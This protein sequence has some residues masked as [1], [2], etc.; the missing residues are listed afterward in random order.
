[1]QEAGLEQRCVGREV[2]A[3]SID[4]IPQNGV[5]Q[6]SEHVQRSFFCCPM[7]PLSDKTAQNM[8]IF[9]YRFVQVEHVVE[10]GLGTIVQPNE[11]LTILVNQAYEMID[12]VGRSVASLQQADY[13]SKEPIATNLRRENCCNRA[14]VDV[15]HEE[16]EHNRHEGEHR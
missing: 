15:V 8:T 1:M 4:Q 5:F 10:L 3:H 7:A 11:E 6:V 9:R 2:L 12:V 14:G 16:S 13:R